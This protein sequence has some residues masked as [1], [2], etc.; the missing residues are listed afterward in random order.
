MP[1]ERAGVEVVDA[2]KASIQ[3]HRCHRWRRVGGDQHLGG[4]AET[5][6]HGD[7]QLDRLAAE[8]SNG[9]LCQVNASHFWHG[10]LLQ[11]TYVAFIHRIEEI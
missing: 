5:A 9:D 4:F 6:E 1:D 2:V 3:C 7:W 8:K 11:M 10:L